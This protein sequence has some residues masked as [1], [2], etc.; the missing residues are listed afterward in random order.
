MPAAEMTAPTESSQEKKELAGR[1]WAWRTAVLVM[2]L[3]LL[4][5]LF[6]W[7]LLGADAARG[8]FSWLGYNLDDSC[9]Y[10]SWMR[11]AADGHFFQRNLF[12]T[13]EQAGHQFNLF[14]LLLGNTARFFHLPLLFVY[15]LSRLILGAGLLRSVWWLLEMLVPTDGAR[16]TSFLLV[17]FSAGLGWLPGL[18]HYSGIESPVD[19]W[20]PEA[21]TFLCLYLSPLFLV[22]LLLMVGTI[23]NLLAAERTGSYRYALYAGLCGLLLGNIHTYDVIT[24]MAVWGG[25]LVLRSCLERELDVRAWGQA[26]LAGL[27]TGI[28]TGYTFYLLKTEDVFRARAAVATLSPDIR[29]YLLA[30]GPLM[31]LAI[32]GVRAAGRGSEDPPLVTDR[33]ALSL[34]CAWAVINL[35]VAYLPVAFNRKMLMGEHLPLAILAGAGLYA[36]RGRLAKGVGDRSAGVAVYSA[37][38]ILALTNVLFVTRDV[39]NYLADR[40]Q[41]LIQRPYMFA[42]EAAA[43]GWLREHALPGV[44]IQPL[45]WI[46]KTATGKIA[47][48]DTTMACFAPGLTG[49]PVDAGHWGETPSFG[50]A[51]LQWVKFMRLTTSNKDRLALLRQSGVRYVIF[52][53]KRDEGLADP[54]DPALLLLFRQSPPSFL[55][56]VPEASNADADVYEVVLP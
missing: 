31:L 37:V 30:Y 7:S 34:L 25:Y 39:Q 21:I 15:H 41:S 36:L 26:V 19:V 35:A 23:G 8:W 52:S 43:L 46:A 3:T 27:L 14:F 51:M 56:L 1:R 10:L 40:G 48:V 17:C 11:Q 28:S 18:W 24:L 50:P 13:H 29:L 20:Q 53:Q 33:R 16:K 42:G 2:A 44:P 49:H 4:P 47:F 22:S 12:T 55:R 32:L 9:V 45:P 5:Y 54:V 6:G 38:G